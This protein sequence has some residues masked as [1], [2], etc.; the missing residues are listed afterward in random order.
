MIVGIPKERKIQEYRVGCTP[1]GVQAFVKRGH[2]VYFET[3]C[4]DGSGFTDEEYLAAG[5]VAVANKEQVWELADMVIKVKEPIPEEYDL[6]KPNQ[7]LYTYLHLAANPELTKVLLE[8]K[9]TAIA[10][11]TFI[12]KH[13]D[14]PLL[15]PMSEIA[16]KMSVQQGAKGLEK[17]S[18]GRG[19]LLGGVGGGPRGEGTIIGGGTVGLSAAKVAIGMG[20]KVNIL[21]IN[22]DRL[23]Y[24]D[25]LFENRIQTLYSSRENIAE[26]VKRSDLVIGAVLIAGAKAPKLVT[27]EMVKA[28]KYGAVIVDVSVDQGGCIETS[29]PTTHEN[30]TYLCNGVV[31][32]C[33]TNIPGIVSRTSTMALTNVT[34]K[35]GLAIAESG[36]AIL[37]SI[38][39]PIIKSGINTYEGNLCCEAVA[40]S[41][42]MECY[43]FSRL[44]EIYG[45]VV[46]KK[47]SKI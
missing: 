28:M 26:C 34:L 11:E 44:E 27:E 2:M 35:Y 3:K 43:S 1:A 37:A 10:Y 42:G 47:D 36:D 22:V 39:E 7:I 45:D 33:I 8:K 18:E 40:D 23:S 46:Y 4:G 24:I 17:T 9:I 16:G 38:D 20:A 21:D 29:K 13:G 41:L 25:D 6:M 5:G 12:N 30:P 32:S 31:H 19:V 14:L 15:E